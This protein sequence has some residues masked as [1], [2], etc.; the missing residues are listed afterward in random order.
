M[1]FK[2]LNFE[3][4]TL[5]YEEFVEFLENDI[6]D[7]KLQIIQKKLKNLVLVNKGTLYIINEEYKI[8]EPYICQS[9]NDISTNAFILS[10]VKNILQ[11]SYKT[12]TKEQ[13]LSL[14]NNYKNEMK[15]TDMGV[16]LFSDTYFKNCVDAIKSSITR[17]DIN[18]NGVN[19][20]QIHFRNGY[21]DL[22]TCK[23]KER[24]L[25]KDF[26]SV[27]INRDY[28]KPPK[29]IISLIKNT[30]RKIISPK[31]DF[32]R[33]F[34]TLGRSLS[35]DVI[36]DQSNL[37]LLGAG[38]NGKSVLMMMVKYALSVY[39]MEMKN[40]TFTEGNNKIDKILNE[41]QNKE[42]YRFAWINEMEDRKIDQSLFK[43]FCEGILQTTTL[44]RDGL[45]NFSHFA[46]LIFTA[47]TFPRLIMDGGTVRRIEAYECMS[48][49]VDEPEEVNEEENI[50]LK[51]KKFLDE[52]ENNVEYQNA[53]F[54]ILAK[55]CK[56]WCEDK[57]K[58]PITDNFKDTKNMVVNLNDTIQNFIDDHLIIN[59]EENLRMTKTELYDL[60]KIHF[61]KSHINESQIY[62]G[63]KQK[64][65]K[66]SHKLRCNN[67][68]GC[69]YS[70]KIKGDGDYSMIN[71]DIENPKF[72]TDKDEIIKNQ[73]LEI[74]KLKK[75]IET[76]LKQSNTK[77][78]IKQPVYKF[79]TFKKVEEVKKA[80]EDEEVK[81]AEEVE[82]DIYLTDSDDD[83]IEETKPIKNKYKTYDKITDL[84]DDLDFF[85]N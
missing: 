70:V 7:D 79:N 43:Q 21:M 10:C 52:F 44:Y 15:K 35:G 73:A 84:K 17:N 60:F 58:Y 11:T 9:D 74:E 30:S 4:N 56:E 53:F 69:F 62:S 26:I 20:Y 38:S 34:S 67:K 19:K 24:N 39:F 14:K 23:L 66:W 31:D 61:P 29:E 80:E 71:D 5:K 42:F 82:E 45:N 63:L 48:K 13:Q 27:Y 76:L 8:Y 83:E 59:C 78:E 55:Y 72:E 12:F 64:G 2:N 28:K 51:D 16:K 46:K 47:N 3:K 33:I 25:D 32:N 18:F 54:Y 36:I 6:Q 49:F 41:F 50:Y 81:K 40:N 68:Q 37:F 75:Q 77:E 1:N 85:L 65:V 22:K 57:D